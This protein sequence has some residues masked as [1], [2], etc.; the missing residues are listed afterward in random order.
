MVLN[1][2]LLLIKFSFCI[3]RVLLLDGENCG[4]ICL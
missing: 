2:S 4:M 1:V 3:Q